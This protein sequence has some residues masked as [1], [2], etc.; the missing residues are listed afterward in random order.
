M[1][2][3]DADDAPAQEM[4]L[5]VDV[6]IA[7]RF[8]HVSDNFLTFDIKTSDEFIDDVMHVLHTVQLGVATYTILDKEDSLMWSRIIGIQ[9]IGTLW[10]PSMTQPLK[11]GKHKATKSQQNISIIQGDP[12]EAPLLKAASS[13]HAKASN[14]SR[15]RGKGKGR[16]RSGGRGNAAPM[17]ADNAVPSQSSGPPEISAEDPNPICDIDDDTENRPDNITEDSDHEFEYTY[18]ENEIARRGCY[19]DES[20][21]PSADA[22]PAHPEIGP[23][24][25]VETVGNGLEVLAQDLGIVDD[26]EV[27]PNPDGQSQ[28]LGVRPA[29]GVF[30]IVVVPFYFG[31]LRSQGST[32]SKH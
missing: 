7:E 2:N 14:Q 18:G 4:K 28:N 23:N 16:G 13:L 17:V 15:G 21:V 31:C 24:E 29:N 22:T 8:N 20:Q 9:H 5:P 25:N 3:L 27:A 6:K 12:L 32:S 11:L 1:L 19:A 26:A 30:S 10:A